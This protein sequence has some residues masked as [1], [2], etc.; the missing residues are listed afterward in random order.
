MNKFEHFDFHTS[1]ILTTLMERAD[2]GYTGFF[3]YHQGIELLFVHEG[4]GSINVNQKDYEIE[5][6]SLYIF[7]PFQLHRV[8]ISNP[9]QYVRTIFHFEPSYFEKKLHSFPYLNH[10]LTNL[11][12]NKLV[13]H[14]YTD[15]THFQLLIGLIETSKQVITKKND[16][17]EYEEEISLLLIQ[18]LLTL[19]KVVSNKF[20][21]K[22]TFNTKSTHHIEKIINWIDEHYQE[23]FELQSL[24][25]ELHL[26]KYYI[27]HLFK[28]YTS[29]ALTDYLMAK[30][31]KEAC[32]LLANTNLPIEIVGIKVG[33][34]DASYFTKFFKK[35]M[36][37]TPR[38]YRQITIESLRKDT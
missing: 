29:Y 24:A 10:F 26:S 5:P 9:Q 14:C 34:H 3:H 25:N 22:N 11:W 17:N 33:I 32:L 30:R 2:E 35:R 1:P 7:Q 6:N 20:F 8:T 18:F 21:M 15:S 13:E 12:K 4:T 31:L 16:N 28:E 23:D 38:K 37:M 36:G 19:K 27:S